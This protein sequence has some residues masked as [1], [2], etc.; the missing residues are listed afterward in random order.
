MGISMMKRMYGAAALMVSSLVLAGCSFDLS[1]IDDYDEL[2]FFDPM[3]VDVLID[4]TMDQEIIDA[5]VQAIAKYGELD[6][7][8]VSYELV[9]EA[10]Q[11]YE[12]YFSVYRDEDIDYCSDDDSGVVACNSFYYDTGT[13]EIYTS[14]IMFNLNAFDSYKEQF[15]EEYLD[16]YLAVAL[17]E[18][19]H[20]FGLE[21][22]YSE[23]YRETSIMYYADDGGMFTDLL[24]YDIERLRELYG[25]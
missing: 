13:N 7:I 19:G 18:F 11:E 3:D 23:H 8:D 17:H 1:I 12:V 25:S 2:V 22:L 24:P 20:T 14:Q 5:T 4:S 21:D 15:P 9:A 10:P 16:Y 6:F